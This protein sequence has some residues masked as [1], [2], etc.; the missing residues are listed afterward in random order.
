MV[1]FGPI[2]FLGSAMNVAN[3]SYELLCYYL[4]GLLCNVY[5]ICSP[6]ASAQIINNTVDNF[7][8]IALNNDLM[9]VEE[10]NIFTLC[11]KT[12]HVVVKSIHLLIQPVMLCPEQRVNDKDSVW[13]AP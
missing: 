12:V 1:K 6:I 8:Y 9:G 4:G 13:V 5:P 2:Q 11:T 10:M 7:I 3:I